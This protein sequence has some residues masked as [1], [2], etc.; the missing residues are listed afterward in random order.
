MSKNKSISDKKLFCIKIPNQN[1]K[2]MEIINEIFLIYN[3]F[4]IFKI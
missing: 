2:Q 1:N 4:K 3:I